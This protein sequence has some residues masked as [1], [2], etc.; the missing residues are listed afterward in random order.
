MSGG[1]EFTRAISNS[2]LRIAPR[3]DGFGDG[4]FFFFATRER[5]RDPLANFFPE[6]PRSSYRV[7]THTRA[8]ET[9]RGINDVKL[10]RGAFFPN[11]SQTRT[12]RTTTA[13]AAADGAARRISCEAAATH[14]RAYGLQLRVGHRPLSWH[15][16][17]PRAQI[18]IYIAISSF[19]SRFARIAKTS[20][21]KQL[22]LSRIVITLNPKGA[23]TLCA[24]RDGSKLAFF[25]Y[26]RLTNNANGHIRRICTSLIFVSIGVNSQAIF[27]TKKTRITTNRA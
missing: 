22:E 5:E 13:A 7:R 12:R 17:V 15:A 21:P 25:I 9:E 2:A 24:I 4:T 23:I 16:R 19:L 26:I 11:K 6:E 27:L 10:R 20:S 14:V 3:T 1:S 18:P 8:R